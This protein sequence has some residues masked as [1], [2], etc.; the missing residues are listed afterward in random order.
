MG[1][2]PLVKSIQSR[3]HGV[4]IRAGG[5][6]TLL[7]IITL[8]FV[9]SALCGAPATA[10]EP[11]RELS[12]LIWTEY[13]DPELIAEFEAK[14]NVRIKST[15]FESDDVRDRMVQEVE[16][17]GFDIGLV[18]D[19]MVG[20]YAR[21]GWIAPID[22]AAVPNLKHIDPRWLTAYPMV[23]T[24]GVPYFWGTLG[25]AYRKDLI[26]RPVTS[27]MDLFRPDEALRGRIIMVYDVRD[28]I[29]MALRALGYSVNATEPEQLAEAARLLERQKPYV[30]NYSYVSLTERSGM[31]T[32][33]FA[34]T[35]LYSGDALMLQKYNDNI[36][37]VVPSEG[38]N[39]WTDYLV[40][41]KNSLHKDLALDFINFL[42]K[43]ENAARLAQFVHYASPNMAAR[44]YLPQDF[45]A[46]LTIFPPDEV[47]ARSETYMLLPPKTMK[48]RNDIF[49][50]LTR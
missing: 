23:E 5:R 13:V 12:L 8:A 45:L 36:Q 33:E 6:A 15:Y 11:P 22:K 39:L 26:K 16:G 30:R 35:M 9:L 29:G 18:N 7:S 17:G 38:T 24:Y 1:H 44:K 50:R 41:F 27:W 37:Y 46:D 14:H 49:A 20:P 47:I 19:V 32:G 43:P 4:G 31:V 40:I 3:A 28:T 21:R 10:K 25:I 42:N 2:N 34:M 48:T